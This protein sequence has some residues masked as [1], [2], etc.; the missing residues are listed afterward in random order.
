M[1]ASWIPDT[2]RFSEGLTSGMLKEVEPYPDGEVLINIGAVID[3]SEWSHDLPR[4][5]K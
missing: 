5:V 2:G 3:I 1:M 4:S